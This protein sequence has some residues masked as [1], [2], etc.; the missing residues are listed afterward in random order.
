MLRLDFSVADLALPENR[1]K[2][3]RSSISGVQDKVQL[4]RV[5]GK[6]VL[7]E[8]GGDYI[9]KPVPRN[10][11]AELAAD[12]P[13]N[14][15]LTMDIARDVFGIRTAEHAL[16]EMK[17]GEPAYLTKRFDRRNGEPIRQEDFCQLSGRSSETHGENYKYDASYEELAELV[18][19]FCPAA[20]VENPKVFFLVL[21]NYVFANGDAHLKNFSLFQSPQG[22]YILTPAY[23][24]LNTAVHFPNEPSATALDFFADGHFTPAYETLGFHSSADFVELGAAFGV[25]GNEVR[26]ALA[27]FAARR[28]AVER[29]IA[30]SRLSAEARTRYLSKFADRLR[31]ISQ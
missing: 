8:S 31:A 13:I 20:A 15:A 11:A 6:F 10:T 24:L 23:D 4:R 25:P 27:L 1:A 2:T 29:R 30:V 22:D 17:D 3:R 28:D 21:F 26:E 7:A 16:V 19:R 9:L 18:R 5:R 12:I 14:E